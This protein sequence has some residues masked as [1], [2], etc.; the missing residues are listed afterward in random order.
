VFGDPL[1]CCDLTPQV[2]GHLTQ[3]LMPLARGKLVIALEGGYNIAEIAKCSVECVNVLNGASPNA[4]P[5]TIGIDEDVRTNEYWKVG[6]LH[7]ESIAKAI[8]VQ[9]PYWTSLSFAN[10]LLNNNK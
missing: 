8:S 5:K 3:M 9:A 1:G 7:I 6:E 2:Y 4:I 10:A